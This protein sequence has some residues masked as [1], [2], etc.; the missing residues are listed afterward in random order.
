MV[1]GSHL[2]RRA[3]FPI[4]RWSMGVPVADIIFRIEDLFAAKTE[5][6]IVQNDERNCLR[7]TR[8]G[9]LILQK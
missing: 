5:F 1:S 7:L 6:V 4:L 8:R 9:K 2:Y 3:S